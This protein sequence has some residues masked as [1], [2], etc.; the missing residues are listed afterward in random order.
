MIR[1]GTVPVALLLSLFISPP[2]WSQTSSC[3]KIPQPDFD[4]NSYYAP[5]T[6]LSGEALKSALNQIIRNHTVYSYSPCTWEILREA[7]ED[8][9]NSANVIGIYTRRSIPKADQDR[10]TNTPDYW[11]RE[12]IWPKN[13][14]FPDRDQHAH[15]DT[16]M[17]RAA[18]KSTNA[19]RG[20]RDF[21]AGGSQHWECS[22]CSFTS[23]TWEPPDVVKGDIARSLFYMDTRYEGGDSSQTPDLELLDQVTSLGSPNLGELCQ[24][25]QWHLD[26]PVS[27]AEQQRNDIIYSWQGNRNPF[28]DHPEYVL[29]I[30]GNT[31]GIAP[32]APEAPRETDADVP[33]P[34]WMLPMLAGLLFTGLRRHGK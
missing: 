14:G 17:L 22:G 7:D 18:D 26:D 16:H 4:A 11:N 9:N 32:P 29:P 28:I 23:T 12:H 2:A 30:W 5:A 27:A 13:R 25:V 31:C 8:P 15:N 20:N 19:D 10:G 34:L 6:G 24:L 1:L 3:P 33:L 21:A